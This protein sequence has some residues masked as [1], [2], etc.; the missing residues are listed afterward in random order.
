LA[1]DRVLEKMLLES[2]KKGQGKKEKSRGMA[3]GR[4]GDGGQEGGKSPE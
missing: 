3:N 2:W 1:Y 4:E